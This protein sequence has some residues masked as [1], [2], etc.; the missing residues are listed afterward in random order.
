MRTDSLPALDVQQQIQAAEQLF[1]IHEM[2]VPLVVP[3]PERKSHFYGPVIPGPFCIIRRYKIFG[4]VKLERCPVLVRFPAGAVLSAPN[5]GSIK[6]WRSR[7]FQRSVREW[8]IF[9]EKAF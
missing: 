6:V 8:P 5:N 2:F 3:F 1:G 7:V 9:S 4:S